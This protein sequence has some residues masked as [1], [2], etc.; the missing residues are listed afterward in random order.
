MFIAINNFYNF[1]SIF[2]HSLSL[3]SLQSIIPF[4][5]QKGEHKQV[6]LVL[7][8]SD[9]VKCIL[10]CL[11]IHSHENLEEEYRLQSSLAHDGLTTAIAFMKNE[12]YHYL[13]REYVEGYTVTE[14]V[15]MSKDGRLS[16][17]LII[18]I[19]KQLC[20]VLHYLH[21]RKPPIIH[22]D[23]KPDNV[24][25]TTYGRVKLIDF[26]ISRYFQDGLNRDTI[27]MGTKQMTPPEQYGYMQT[28]ARSDIYSLGILMF[29]MATGSVDI[30]EIGEY[31]VAGS[32]KK[33]IRRCTRFTPKER[34]KNVN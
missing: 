21:S 31:K 26:S 3:L 2:S 25:I 16:D 28:N 23:I 1:H 19:T 15:V 24:I 34:Y 12:S 4:S 22:R 33:C 27:I 20:Q 7:R 5:V 9:D 32:V 17:E 13:T 11:S 8:K 30:N 14:K 29:Y 10:K 6:Y 18:N